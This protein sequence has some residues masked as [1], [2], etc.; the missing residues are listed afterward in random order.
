MGEPVIRW[1]LRRVGLGYVTRASGRM[2]R[3]ES[4]CESSSQGCSLSIGRSAL[5]ADRRVFACDE[6]ESTTFK[7]S[8]PVPI[9]MVGCDLA[10]MTNCPSRNPWFPPDLCRLVRGCFLSLATL[11]GSTA[12]DVPLARIAEIRSL[13]REQAAQALPVRVRGVV[14][15]R[16]GATSL[17]VQD[18]SAGIWISPVQSRER[19]LMA[20]DESV[21]GMLEEGMEVEIEGQSD[22]GG[23][24]PQILPTAVR[25][26]GRQPLPTPLVMEP[27]SFFSGAD[28]CQRVEVRGVVQGFYPS[29]N[30]VTLMLD[31]NPGRFSALVTS[32]VA[33]DPA[34]LVDAEVRLRGVAATIFN[35]RGEVT[36][37]R[38]MAG[39]KGDLVVEKP[40]PPPDA[41]PKV[42]LDRLLPFRAQTTGPHRVWVEGTVTYSLTGKFFYLQEGAS[43]V[44]VDTRSPI[45][46]K[47]GDRV[48]A[49]GFVDM[50]RLIGTLSDATVR[51]TGVASLPEPVR[52]SPEEIFALNDVAVKAGQVALP[53]DYDGH[54]IRC[55]ARL[56]AVQA[57]PGNKQPRTLIL[58][59]A[60]SL[61]K[62]TL[63][64][65]ALCDDVKT[66]ALE[67]L[68][69]GSELEITGL[70]QLDYAPKD[71]PSRI[72]RTVPVSLDLILRSS[73]DV[74][75][76]SR[77]SWWTAGHLSAVLAA[78]VLALGGALGWNLQL[79]RQVRR[80]T[81]LL[82]KE[83]HA[84]RD[85]SIEFQATL[86]E[87][88]RLATNLHDTLL[89]TISGLGFQIE[90]CEAEV[91]A[92]QGD[93]QSPS[94]LEV[95]RRM[96]DH[97]ATELRNSVWALRS[98]PLNG[99]EL[100]EAL[101]AIA[102]RLGAGHPSRIEVRADGDLS[103][104]PDFIAGNLLLF[105]Q[106]AVH[107]SLKHGHPR[108]VMI[109]IQ[110]LADPDRIS[111]MV[112]DDG[113]GFTPGSEAG[114]DQGH[115]GLQG[116]RER[117]ERLDGILRIH[118]SP[119]KGTTLQAEVALRIYD[120]EM[121]E[122]TFASAAVSF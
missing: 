105:V 37:C 88:T 60:N 81:K 68:Q 38:V 107:N 122:P 89:Q 67:S 84:R 18:A 16:R 46:L 48:E 80:K 86:R 54:L 56:L 97:A 9:S 53:H 121:S 8:K 76:L 7:D 114:V 28:D 5:P 92:P 103:R 90:A 98:L 115:F 13:P 110:M 52:I 74:V 66:A 104:V 116:M 50:S 57:D 33:P 63:I 112:R 4:E 44:R 10:Q 49:A 58:E 59:R 14:T 62:G 41:V 65:R 71:I 32:A 70:V 20:W 23:Y 31:A 55:R 30:G 100:P 120:D 17:T 51:L 24:A 47:P 69:P 3:R 106:E 99:M 75:V 40:P 35:T 87:R 15:W 109:E 118:S 42:T 2:T 12:G 29:P 93:E 96:V 78:V 36:G 79:K 119:G 26:L 6:R 113:S 117:I 1:K 39:V 82:A 34:A 77:P 101:G 85:A 111:L 108:G 27:A 83:M 22:P 43:A 45:V 21:F 64:F 25:I 19:G 61:N 91:P 11:A 94:H 73:A 95:A 72:I 102:R